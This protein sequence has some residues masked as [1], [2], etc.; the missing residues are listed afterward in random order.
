MCSGRRPPQPSW[1]YGL[2]PELADINHPIIG[3]PNFDPYPSGRWGKNT[4][5]GKTSVAICDKTWTFKIDPIKG[6]QKK[7]QRRKKRWNLQGGQ[8]VLRCAHAQKPD[9]KLVQIP[10]KWAITAIQD[11]MIL[12]G[13]VVVYLSEKWKSELE[14]F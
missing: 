7:L 10:G 13:G 2:H 14:Q 8:C 9:P 12:V 6:R 4:F 1:R 3:V 5:W 11:L